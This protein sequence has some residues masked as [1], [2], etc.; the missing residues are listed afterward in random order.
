MC[1]NK[2]SLYD[3]NVEDFRIHIVQVNVNGYDIVLTFSTSYCNSVKCRDN[4]LRK[5]AI[6]RILKNIMFVLEI[7]KAR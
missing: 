5:A 7:K 2:T 4:I 6:S 1:R 3:P